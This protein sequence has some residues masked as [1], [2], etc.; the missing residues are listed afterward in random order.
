MKERDAPS[1]LLRRTEPTST[2]PRKLSQHHQ[3]RNPS[4][5]YRSEGSLVRRLSQKTFV[6]L[7]QVQTQVNFITGAERAR[8]RGRERGGG[9]QRGG[10]F[11]TSPMGLRRRAEQVSRCAVLCGTYKTVKAIFRPWL[12]GISP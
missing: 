11:S 8:A 5:L 4:Q 7:S 2:Q 6:N 9:G 12:S 10:A 3:P 1:L